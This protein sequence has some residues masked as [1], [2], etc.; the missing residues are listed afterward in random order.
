[1]SINGKRVGSS[2]VDK[3]QFAMWSADEIANVGADRET[4]VSR[5]Y[6]GETSTFTGKIDKVTIALK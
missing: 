5:Q 3:T 2:R 1:M 6:T 4:P